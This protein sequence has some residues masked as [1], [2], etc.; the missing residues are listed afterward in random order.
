MRLLAALQ[1]PKAYKPQSYGVRLPRLRS[2]PSL[3]VLSSLIASKVVRA[4]RRVFPAMPTKQFR[5]LAGRGFLV[6][7][8]IKV[9]GT[10]LAFDLHRNCYSFKRIVSPLC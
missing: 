1:A 9:L 3:D 6:G 8:F 10:F 2:M 4:I 5:G 7:Q